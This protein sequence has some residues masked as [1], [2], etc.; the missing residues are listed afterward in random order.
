MGE[1]GGTG[2]WEGGGKVERAG[3]AEG[4]G[5]RRERNVRETERGDAE[6]GVRRGGRAGQ[7]HRFTI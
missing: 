6:K 3:E 4:G 2:G 5:R 1:R 7:V